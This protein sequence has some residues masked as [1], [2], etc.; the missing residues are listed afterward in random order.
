MIQHLIDTASRYRDTSVS[1]V[2]TASLSKLLELSGAMK[3]FFVSNVVG[4]E[5]GCMEQFAE[6]DESFA[7][8]SASSRCFRMYIL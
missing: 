8:N 1:T 7:L 6:S 2:V 3:Q 4:V 5:S